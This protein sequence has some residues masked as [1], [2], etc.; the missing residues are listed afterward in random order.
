M[1]RIR[2]QRPA[3]IDGVYHEAGAIVQVGE[4]Y[5]LPAAA[6][7]ASQDGAPG[8]N[9]MLADEVT[10]QT[11]EVHQ[12]ARDAALVAA[13]LARPQELALI[14]LPELRQALADG[15]AGVP[16]SCLTVLIRDGKVSLHVARF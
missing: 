8:N 10:E 1:I 2:L 12:L 5:P 14:S 16:M 9:R 15:A 11:A 6:Q 13:A 4:D 3:Q 7:R